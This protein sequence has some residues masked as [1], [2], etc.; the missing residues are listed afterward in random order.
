MSAWIGVWRNL[1][2]QCPK[3]GD[4]RGKH[5]LPSTFLSLIRIQLANDRGGSANCQGAL[6]IQGSRGALFE[7]RL[8]SHGYTLVAKWM[9]EVHRKHLLHESQVYRQ[10]RSIQGSS[11]PVCL[12]KVDL[13]L[14]YYYDTGSIIACS[15][16]AGRAAHSVNTL[17]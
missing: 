5:I 7:V 16:L 3:L 12:G 9:K 15:S 13:E 2:D 17:P 1:D 4:H 6:Y 8:S 10:L 11:I 14:P